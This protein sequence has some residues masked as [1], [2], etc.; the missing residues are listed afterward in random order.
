MLGR[1]VG[2][3]VENFDEGNRM[4]QNGDKKC[5]RYDVLTY[6]TRYLIG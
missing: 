4:W 1:R 5:V 6:A 2:V 3:L